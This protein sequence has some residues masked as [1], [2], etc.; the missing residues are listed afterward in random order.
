MVFSEITV[1]KIKQGLQF[2]PVPE[3]DVDFEP[4]PMIGNMNRIY[5][6]DDTKIAT[7]ENMRVRECPTVFV[8]CLIYCVSCIDFR[9]EF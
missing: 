2:I 5:I 1:P 4:K 8:L 9:R 6:C 3:Y 7:K